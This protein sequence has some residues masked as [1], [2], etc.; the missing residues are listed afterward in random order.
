M[1]FHGLEF[2]EMLVEDIPTLSPIMKRAFDD[3]AQLFFN[4]DA[5][6]PPGYDDGSFLKQWGIESDALSYKISL[7]EKVIGAIMVFID[8]DNQ[9]GFLGN[10]F[11]DSDLIGHGYG[12]T[13]WCFIE[14][15]YPQI[16][17]WQ[18]ET[19][20][21][22]YRNHRFYINKCGFHVFAVEGDDNRFEAMFKLEKIIH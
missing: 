7:N 13:A 8:G 4:Q 3:D 15:T 17:I 21:V 11:I 14:N 16:K 19:P 12:Y 18:T 2:T 10:L 9:R 6:G 20:A 22:S 5:G 1:F